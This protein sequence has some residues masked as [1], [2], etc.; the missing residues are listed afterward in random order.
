MGKKAQNFISLFAG[1]GGLDL[2]FMKQ[3]F[4][5][6]LANDIE[7]YS[8]DTFK[9]N[10][11]K[12]PFIRD[13]I[14]N[15]SS[16]DVLDKTGNVYP[17]IIL[18]GPPCQGFSVMGDKTTSDIRNTLF[19]NYVKLVNELKPSC[20]L[21]ENVK[22]IKTMYNGRFFEEVVN[23]FSA[24]GYNIFYRLINSAD[25]GVPQNRE[26]VFIFGTRLSFNWSFPVPSNKS[27]KN[28][29]AYNN[30]G[31]AIKDLEC[32]GNEIPNHLALNHNDIV[33]DRYRLIPEGGKLPPPDKLPSRIRRKNFGNTYVRLHRYKKSTTLVPGNNAFPKLT[34]A[35]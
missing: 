35:D 10:W 25:Y 34:V 5:C 32:A 27:V 20:F 17:D 15:I 19:L 13:D 2:G 33:V 6:I 22:G 28:I 9:K 21:F 1:A 31:D 16:A 23:A 11:P 3:G 7:K 18:G 30:V 29:K 4:N 8:E 26:R 14:R 24:V 12:I